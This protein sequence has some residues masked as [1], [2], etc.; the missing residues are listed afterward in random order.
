MNE[1]LLRAVWSF[2]L[3]RIVMEKDTKVPN[4]ASFIINK[5]D[6]SLGNLLRG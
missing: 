6:H 3:S 5:E 2:L 4:A 1:K